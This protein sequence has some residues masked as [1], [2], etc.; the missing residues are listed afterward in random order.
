MATAKT[1]SP[2]GGYSLF[3]AKAG[4]LGFLLAVVAAGLTV[5]LLHN[6]EAHSFPN[7]LDVVKTVILMCPIAVFSCGPYGLLAG[8]IGGTVLYLRRKRI[9]TLKRL[10]LEA[11]IA[12]LLMGFAFP[13]FDGAMN[14]VPVLEF[15]TPATGIFSILFGVICALLCALA[16]RQTFVR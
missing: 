4:A 9:Q 3:A 12:G 16:F 10:L 13:I 2:G 7:P 5:A 14:S 8:V 1:A 11:A 15:L 6:L